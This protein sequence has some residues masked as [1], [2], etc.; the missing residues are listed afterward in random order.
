M[1]YD[2]YILSGPH[3]SL[4]L[5]FWR[6]Y[7]LVVRLATWT[8][9]TNRHGT[10]RLFQ[11]AFYF[12]WTHKDNRFSIYCNDVVPFMNCP[13]TLPII[14]LIHFYFKRRTRPSSF[15]SKFFN[16]EKF[17]HSSQSQNQVVPLQIQYPL[18][19]WNINAMAYP[20]NPELELDMTIT[21]FHKTTKFCHTKFSPIILLTNNFMLIQMCQ[22]PINS[23]VHYFFSIHFI[24]NFMIQSIP[25]LQFFIL[26]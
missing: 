12:F 20:W 17:S 19:I 11:S 6:Y 9:K 8:S 18:R 13:A 4:F 23:I 25:H 15:V 16:R 26:R 24:H 1:L 2:S 21:S 14:T 5:A 10:T 22:N 3:L 7:R